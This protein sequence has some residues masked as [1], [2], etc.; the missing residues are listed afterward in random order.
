MKPGAPQLKQLLRRGWTRKQ[1]GQKYG[2]SGSG[3]CR[4][5][6]RL[7]LD[8]PPEGELLIPEVSDLLGTNLPNAYRMI[9]A[10]GIQPRCWGGRRTIT[11]REFAHLQAQRPAPEM[12][13][14]RIPDGTYTAAQ[15]AERHGLPVG[16]FRTRI[17]RAGIR[18]AA[19]LRREDRRPTALYTLAQLAPLLPTVSRPHQPPPGYLL[20]REVAEITGTSRTGVHKWAREGAPHLQLSSEGYG[21]AYHPLRLAEW[22]ERTRKLE[23]ARRKARS[24]RRYAESQQRRAA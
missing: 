6:Q 10:A 11:E 1:I 23:Y 14:T 3:V 18:P 16:S 8:T 15:V 21:Y 4:L 19:Y 7:G 17:T 5:L 24:L 20:A 22:I 12:V 13:V 9:A 2:L